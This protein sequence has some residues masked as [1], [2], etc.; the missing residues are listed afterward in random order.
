MARCWTA[1]VRNRDRER[2]ERAMGGENTARRT[3]FRPRVDRLDHDC[4]CAA[5][6]LV[7]P[8][9]RAGQSRLR[10]QEGE[11]GEI[12]VELCRVELHA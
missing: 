6:T 5:A 2:E 7:A 4:A 12:G 1:S 10:A 9:L 8:L 11:E 3:L